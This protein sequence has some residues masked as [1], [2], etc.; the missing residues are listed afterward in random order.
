MNLRNQKGYTL[1]EILVA[2]LIIAII[3]TSLIGT[4]ALQ[5]QSST[6]QGSIQEIQETAQLALTLIKRDLMMAGYGVMGALSLYFEDGGS[7]N[8]DIIYINDSSFLSDQELLDGTW[9][10]AQITGGSGTDT[11]TVDRV[12][13]DGD[14]ENE[15]K[16]DISMR[17]I[18]DGTSNKVARI[19]NVNGNQLLLDQAVNGS[20]VAPAL[21][22]EIS[23]NNLRKSSM[24]ISGT[25]PLASNVVDLQVAYQDVN[26]T[27][28]CDGSGPCPMS[29]F[30]ANNI[31]LIRVSI[32]TQSRPLSQ[33]VGSNSVSAENG[34]TFSSSSSNK[35]IYRLYTIYIDPRN[36][37]R[38]P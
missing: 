35:R 31:R 17:I 13:I 37:P 7:G 19:L 15:F 30:Q 6:K 12:D 2:M 14:G 24:S 23:S 5:Q 20:Y 27:W 36:L 9:A 18:T 16:D 28:Y 22:Y 25:Q 26:G 10:Q 3:T 38:S 1:V 4:F 34:P 8:P 32:I 29:P 21:Y 11:I 33:Q